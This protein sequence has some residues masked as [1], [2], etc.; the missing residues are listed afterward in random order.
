MSFS[1]DAIQALQ[2][3]KK[4]LTLAAEIEW[5]VDK[6]RAKFENRRSE[7]G[8]RF[9]DIP[10]EYYVT[11]DGTKMVKPTIPDSV[12]KELH[13]TYENTYRE[14]KEAYYACLKDD[15]FLALGRA[16]SEAAKPFFNAGGSVACFHITKELD[17]LQT[18]HGKEAVA[19]D[20]A[21]FEKLIWEINR[22]GDTFSGE[23]DIGYRA[24][25]QTRQTQLHLLR[26]RIFDL[27]EQITKIPHRHK[28]SLRNSWV[29]CVNAA[30]KEV[31]QNVGYALYMFDLLA[32]LR[33]ELEN[34]RV[35][36]LTPEELAKEKKE[37]EVADAEF[38]AMMA[39]EWNEGLQ[40]GEELMYH[41]EPVASQFEI[42]ELTMEIAVLK[43]TVYGYESMIEQVGAILDSKASIEEKYASLEEITKGPEAER[44]Y[45]RYDKEV[46][47]FKLNK[48]N[49]RG[50]KPTRRY[51][52][53]VLWLNNIKDIEGK[54]LTLSFKPQEEDSYYDQNGHS[55][56][57]L[58]L[59]AGIVVDLWTDKSIDVVVLKRLDNRGNNILC[60]IT[61]G[62]QQATAIVS[63]ELNDDRQPVVGT[64]LHQHMKVWQ[65]FENQVISKTDRK[66]LFPP[67]WW[68]EM[69]QQ[70]AA[71]SQAAIDDLR[72]KEENEN[73]ASG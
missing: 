17:E 68:A 16:V 4:T 1:D 21:E 57:M 30:A 5:P 63:V 72:Q 29:V 19:E 35:A 3:H 22:I 53:G 40:S 70:I 11:W 27:Y 9:P 37:K 38:E 24:N 26:G 33:A 73:K 34:K 44:L 47:N 61:N 36:Q 13:H 32:S 50:Q 31:L 8:D 39:D 10:E 65:H 25:K 15:E 56:Q 28:G 66:K 2:Q 69:H 60:K 52:E 46:I 45:G 6:L 64:V 43:E 51:R 71:A 23:Y 48:P 7:V 49:F 62:K 18:D 12:P 67:S 58:A 20:V 14:I 55:R 59:R 42:D 41:N 54:R